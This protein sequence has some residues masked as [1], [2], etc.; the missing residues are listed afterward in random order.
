MAQWEDRFLRVEGI[1]VHYVVAGEGPAVLLV[2][3]LG[4][5]LAAWWENIAALAQNHRVYAIDL[6]GSGDSDKPRHVRYDAY[7]AADFLHKFLNKLNIHRISLI[8]NSAGGLISAIYAINH[9]DR[10]AALVLVS[11]AGL[12]RPLAWFL[13]LA[14]VPLL[15]RLLHFWQGKSPKHILRSVFYTPKALS[16]ELFHELARV[17]T[18][19]EARIAVIKSIQGGVNLLGL[20]KRMRILERLRN[21]DVPLLIVWGREDKIIPVSH[22]Y[23]AARELPRAQVCI[24]PNCGHWPQMEKA[25]EFNEMVLRFL[26][27]VEGREK[28]VP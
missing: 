13:R 20:R 24:I 23:L 7:E 9:P 1:R 28:V 12:D 16:E 10:V 25:E 11:S 22:A 6:P 19:R 2:H 18:L 26:S 21:V 8:G 17:R 14:S 15:G 27:G 5:S 3:G 4:A